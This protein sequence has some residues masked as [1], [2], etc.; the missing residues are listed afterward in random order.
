MSGRFVSGGTIGAS[1]EAS[2][3]DAAAAPPPPNEK[4]GNEGAGTKNKEWEAVQ[5]ELE[6][7][8]KRRE[9]QRAKAAAGQEPS[10]YDIL[11]ANKG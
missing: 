7:D 3:Q 11:Q 1:G 9:E 4:K 8:R 6:A 5:Q 2:S 10:L